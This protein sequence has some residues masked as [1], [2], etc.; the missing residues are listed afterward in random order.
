MK[1]STRC[2][3][4]SVS[5]SATRGGTAFM[6]AMQDRLKA[7]FAMSA[8]ERQAYLDNLIEQA[9]ERQKERAA[10]NANNPNQGQWQHNRPAQSDAQREA[11]RATGSIPRRLEFRAQTAEFIREVNQP[12]RA[13][14]TTSDFSPCVLWPRRAAP[15]A[16]IGPAD[17]GRR[18][19][20]C[21]IAGGQQGSGQQ[22]AVRGIRGCLLKAHC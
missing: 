5:K 16:A 1:K 21:R 15:A 14:R 11:H 20:A 9:E 13:T 10:A 6:K 4:R 7:F 19:R 8:D 3:R 2:P 12:H 18:A 17:H 22:S